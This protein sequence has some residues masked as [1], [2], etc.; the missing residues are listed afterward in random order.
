MKVYNF[1]EA[2]IQIHGAKLNKQNRLV[3][4]DEEIAKTVNEYTAI[5]IY[6]G[7]GVRVRFKTNSQSIKI[8]ATVESNT[9]DWAIP[10]TGSCGIDV[11]VG[12]GKNQYRLGILNPT[13]YGVTE[14][15]KTFTKE[16]KMETVS[17]LLPR[18]EP[19][20]DL[21]I[22]INDD[23]VIEAPDAYTYE[24]PIVFYGSSITEGGAASSVSKCY[25]SIVTRW[26]DTEYLNLGVSGNAK[27][28][29]TMA[30]YIKNL[31]MSIFVMDYDHN[32]PTPEHLEKT[33]EPFFKTIREANPTLP[34]VMMS[35]PDFD[36]G[37]EENIRRREI[38][39]KTYKNAID[40]GDKNVYFIDG[41]TFFGNTERSICTAEG[42][43]PTDLGFMRMAE[44]IY[45]VLKSILEKKQ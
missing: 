31:D 32:A 8:K 4:M 10:L 29:Q 35:K 16:A 23:A 17:L 5:R 33:H 26:L 36:N 6:A 45:P 28:E 9:I 11:M 24:K 30:N 27:G 39:K 38:I 41:E 3:R 37:K 1:K 43:H 20:L 34:V 19:V 22:S 40:N 12:S 44:V 15:E 25:T 21:E 18:N 2:P 7:A 14:F 42:T 13:N